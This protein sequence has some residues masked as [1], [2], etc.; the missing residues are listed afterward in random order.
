MASISSLNSQTLLP[1]NKIS[2]T[3]DSTNRINQFGNASFIFDNEGQTVTKNLPNLTANYEW[4]HRGRLVKV[5][6]PNSETVEYTYDSLERR[7]S[8][9]S[10]NLTTSYVYDEDD[11]ILDL[12]NDGNKLDYLY[13]SGIDEPIRY[14]QTTTQPLYFLQ[15]HLGS[16]IS[17]TEPSG[18]VVERLQ[19][20][21]FGLTP[22][23]YST[24]YQ[25]TGREK[26]EQTKLMYYRAR[27]YDP[28]Q[29]RFLTEDP[30]G[31]ASGTT[32][33]YSYAA[34]NP[35][36]FK[37]PS[38]EIIWI[39]VI[40]GGI[41][42][43]IASPDTANA[44][45]PQSPTYPSELNS[46]KGPG[47]G[48]FGWKGSAGPTGLAGDCGKCAKQTIGENPGSKMVE[49]PSNQQ[50]HYW[51]ELPDGS[52]L[53]KTLRDNLASWDVPF[54]DIPLGTKY[55]KPK[56]HRQFIKRI[57]KCEG[58]EGAFPTWPPKQPPLKF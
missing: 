48:K 16:T 24:R 15:N 41:I 3:A 56:V 31:F 29:G 53:D 33:F 20:D 46:N 35:L 30:I 21:S 1:T 10:A 2:S 45:G 23:S 40:I 49:T 55:F 14:K 38:G 34:N 26:D 36:K 51:V 7:T 52:M 17:L 47:G 5:I 32:N 37:D 50:P 39:V 57:P 54:F 18:N 13:G 58:T 44:P 22:S 11:V 9:K 6:L 25:Y 28:E 8:S 12:V 43:V 42:V 27:W 4:D 19:Y